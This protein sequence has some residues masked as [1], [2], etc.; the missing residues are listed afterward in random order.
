MQELI[1]QPVAIHHTN[2]DLT[3]GA[4]GRFL[5]A[6]VSR[7]RWCKLTAML[8]SADVLCLQHPSHVLQSRI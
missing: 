5:F 3:Y 2:Y 8:Q 1:M 4:N 7:V 6:Y